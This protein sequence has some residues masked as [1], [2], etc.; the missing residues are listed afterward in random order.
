[1]VNRKIKD[2]NDALL[3]DNSNVAGI[4][5]IKEEFFDNLK[6]DWF[7]ECA[8]EKFNWV[9]S[10]WS[11]IRLDIDSIKYICNRTLITKDYVDWFI[12]ICKAFYSVKKIDM[13]ELR[14]FETTKANHPALII[15]NSLGVILAPRVND[16]YDDRFKDLEPEEKSKE[17]PKEKSEEKPEEKP[18]EKSKE[19]PKEKPKKT[20]TKKSKEKSNKK[21]NKNSKKKTKTVK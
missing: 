3:M 2:Y 20:S 16:E 21:S 18:K 19:K 5:K 12:K 13:D 10:N 7:E 6:I 8:F 9:E 15:Y 1:M 14:I 17:K 11:D 4:I